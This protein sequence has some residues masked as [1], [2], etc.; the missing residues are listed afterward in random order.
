MPQKHFL[1]VII[2]LL[3]KFVVLFTTAASAQKYTD[4]FGLNLDTIWNWHSTVS[5]NG[6]EVFLKHR[7]L[8]T[9]TDYQVL[10][11]YAKSSPA[12][13][14]AISTI[15]S[16]FERKKLAANFT[17]VNFARN[18]VKGRAVLA[19]IHD[20]NYDLMF[21]MGSAATSFVYKEFPNSPIPIVSVC[22]KDPVLLGQMSDYSS[23]SNSNFAFTSL[24]VPIAV[25]LT[26]LTELKPQLRNI[27]ILF[28]EQNTSAV[29][30]QVQPLVEATRDQG[31]YTH[32]IGI[33]DRRQAKEELAQLIP[34]ALQKMRATD[35]NLENSVFWITGST[36]II[37][38][39]ETV[40]Q[41]ANQVPV[42]SV[43][44]DIVR[45]GQDSAVLSIGVGFESNAQVAALY[46]TQILAEDVDPG[47]LPVGLVS[48]PDIAINFNRARNIGL[49]IPFSFFESASFVYDASG[50]VVRHK[51]KHIQ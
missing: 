27:G 44:P 31:I 2:I 21:T 16:E 38:Q 5:A 49:K 34:L 29:T 37:R 33:K 51:G 48:P 25:Q 19:R 14:T 35:P 1:N 24:N 30:T 26:Y 43:V 18:V 45:A 39:I 10:V 12:Y 6:D 41:Y 36:S 9:P 15:L 28:A 11:L 13:D 23:G 32:E 3:L 40:N 46:G 4:W 20:Q 22:A 8:T 42:L 47:S 7:N 17:V 50:D